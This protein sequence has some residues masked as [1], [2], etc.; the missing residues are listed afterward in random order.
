[1][2]NETMWMHCGWSA[3]GL[4]KREQR[5]KFEDMLFY[6]LEQVWMWEITGL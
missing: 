1:M 5:L 3:I 6:G 4:W 2:Y